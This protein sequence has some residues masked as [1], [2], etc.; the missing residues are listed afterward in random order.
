MRYRPITVYPIMRAPGAGPGVFTN[1]VS[2]AGFLNPTLQCDS[3]GV[4]LTLRRGDVDFRT[5]GT[6]GSQTA[7]ATALNG[8]VST[9]IGEMADVVN[10]VFDL[11]SADAGGR[12]GR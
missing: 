3:A 9:A 12:S 5:A 8:L 10:N 6:R 4:Y 11:D 1:V 7:V 2:G